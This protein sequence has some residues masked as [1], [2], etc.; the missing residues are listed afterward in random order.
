MA[1]SILRAQLPATMKAFMAAPTPAPVIVAYAIFAAVSFSVY[2]FVAGRQ[3]SSVITM[4]AI[5]Q[6]FGATLLC[7]QV[8]SRKSAAGISVSS[9]KLDALA[10]GLRLSS[11]TWLNGYLPVDKT[12]DHV[13]QITD[14]V[15]L[16]MILFVMHRVLVVHR[17][18]YQ[19]SEDSFQIGP[20]VLVSLAFAAL[21]HAD[22]DASPLFDTFWMTGLFCGVM[23][24]LPHFSLIVQTGGQA[25]AMTCHYIAATALSRVLSGLFMWEARNDI[26]CKPWI[27]TFNH[28]GFAILAAHVL[29]LLLLGDFAF[30]Y[31]KNVATCGLS[32]PLDL[33]EALNM[34]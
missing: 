7:I 1:P 26:T 15:S 34:V 8:L 6:C 21:L 20:M 28:A 18:S 13:Y 9:L 16:T 24:V 3:Y 4:S 11:T 12:G 29:H 22:M 19:A 31:A 27:G 23:A 30:Y 14:V 33:G 32:A 17:Q 5:V 25:D 2:H 10:I